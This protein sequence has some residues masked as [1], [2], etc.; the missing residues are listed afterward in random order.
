MKKFR[1]EVEGW[2]F[3]IV[4]WLVITIAIVLSG[5]LGTPIFFGG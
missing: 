5:R 4:L 2:L 3:V 1:Y